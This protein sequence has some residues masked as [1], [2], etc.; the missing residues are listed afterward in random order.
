MEKA[1]K[2]DLQFC[3]DIISKDLDGNTIRYKVRRTQKENLRG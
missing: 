2:E 3:T 1:V